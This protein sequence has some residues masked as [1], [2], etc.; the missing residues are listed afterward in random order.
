[1]YDLNSEPL[2]V[3]DV[4]GKAHHLMR[5]SNMGINIPRGFVLPT[6][7]THKALDSSDVLHIGSSV[8]KLAHDR[9]LSW[10]SPSGAPLVVS[11]RSGAPVSMPG[12]METILNVGL[13]RDNLQAFSESVDCSSAFAN[14]CYRRL[15]QMYGTVVQDID[16]Q[17]FNCYYDAAKVFWLEI[18]EAAAA[19]L[20]EKF[21][22]VY[23]KETGVSFPDNST[24]ILIESV[25]AVFDSWN[26]TKAYTYREIEGID[27]KMGTAVIIQQM[28]FG[29]T[30]LLSGTGVVF[31]H[32]PNTG[33]RGLYGDFLHNAQGEDVVAG[34]HKT[35]PI[36]KLLQNKELKPVAKNLQQIMTM[37]H[38]EYKEMVDVEFTIENGK[39]WI[40]QARVAKR[41]RRA[42]VRLCLDMV[43]D[44]S[45]NTESATAR[46]I[47]LLPRTNS[48]TGCPEDLSCVGRGVGV[49][50][51]EVSGRI[52]I[53]KE[54][55]KQFIDSGTPYVY[56]AKE[57]APDDS[58]Q[59][60]H[61]EGILTAQGGTLSHAAVVARGW[62][63]CC[64]VGFEDM[65]VLEDKIQIDS[66]VASVGDWIKI[67]G[68]SGE[69]YL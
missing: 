15:I 14:D 66:L 48:G 12:M 43:K 3:E 44:G 68:S 30:G 21:E 45:L 27:H 39:L 4:G 24:E 18:N 69:V 29:N 10:D 42:S 37:L 26:S 13:T 52:A 32:D 25:H 7:W 47:D 40:L 46:I 61:A 49:T 58:F 2:L 33:Q 50:E 56:I 19:K 62:D 64:V 9:G 31:S 28:I 11:V 65:K 38:M 51:G 20:V 22:K 36:K 23:E 57:T 1:V 59:M 35:L 5:L 8:R 16:K 67:N 17:A 60:K 53:G 41:S 55:I 63:K 34:T 54:S 6:Q